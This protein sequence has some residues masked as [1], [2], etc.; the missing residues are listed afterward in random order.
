[1]GPA[2]HLQASLQ[3]PCL[4]LRVW[5]GD[6]RQLAAVDFLPWSQ[7]R[8]AVG[9]AELRYTTVPQTRSI[10]SKEPYLTS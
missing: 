9:Y 6:R 3:R 7:S 1:M 4:P 5:Y 8:I 10:A 2:G